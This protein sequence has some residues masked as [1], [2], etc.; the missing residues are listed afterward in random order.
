MPRILLV[1]DDETFRITLQALLEDVGYECRVVKDGAEALFQLKTES[2]DLV[3][4]TDLDMPVVSG[5]HLLQ[6]MA[7]QSLPPTI[8]VIIIT[9]HV[10]F[11][12]ERMN[13]DRSLGHMTG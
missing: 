10:S 11:I 5:V 8:S 1:D 3:V 7:E 4:I 12:L 13:Q 6:R 9:S 2:F